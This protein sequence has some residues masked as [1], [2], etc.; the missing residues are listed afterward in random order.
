MCFVCI[1]FKE[2]DT[3]DKLSYQVIGDDEVKIPGDE[4]YFKFEVK[5][6]NDAHVL[7]MQGDASTVNGY[8]IVIG[9]YSH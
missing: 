5:A 1:V 8:E 9:K 4:T 6:C 2:I 7:L 3:P